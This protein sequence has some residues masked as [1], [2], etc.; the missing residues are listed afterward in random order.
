MSV[1]DTEA[2]RIAERFDVSRE[3][4]DRL[5]VYVDL[6]AAWNKTINLIG[7]ST[8]PEIWNRHVADCLQLL[9]L[10][11][12]GT[13]AIA[14]LG[15]GAG[16]PGLVLAIARPIKAHLFEAN[17]KKA[18]FLR[19]AARRMGADAEVH[20]VRIEEAGA[21]A[22]DAVTARALAPLSELLHLAEPFFKKGAIGLF[23]KGQ[24]VEAELTEAT[25]S[26]RIALRAHPS[27]TDSRG[28]ILEI[29][30]ARRAG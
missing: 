6:L 21:V 10:M 29:R 9:P 15:S 20:A 19:E 13:R 12:P 16:L 7:R 8:E 4:L 25:K 11:P 22:V 2:R 26:W 5:Q 24:D 27:S 30:E 3:S 23:H 14:D 17:L 1:P 18:A 28:C